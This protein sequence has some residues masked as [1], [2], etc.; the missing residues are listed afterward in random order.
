[1]GSDQVDEASREEGKERQGKGK[2]GRLYFKS[3][4]SKITENNRTQDAGHGIENIQDIPPH[5]FPSGSP[6]SFESSLGKISRHLPA[7][8]TCSVLRGN[9]GD[10]QYYCY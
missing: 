10:R 5:P 8:G 9:Q 4:S 6:A 1:M 2:G 7:G 3:V